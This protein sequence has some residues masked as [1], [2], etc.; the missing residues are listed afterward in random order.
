MTPLHPQIR[1]VLRAMAEARLRPIEEMTPAEV[2]E[3]MEA[4]SRA[5]KAEPLPVGKVEERL[6]P[7]P[8]GTSACGFTGPMSRQRPCLRSFIFMVAA[9]LS[10]ASTQ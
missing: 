5:R 9:M 8:V 4:T 1:D 3:Q 6:V 10:A 2:R 7:A